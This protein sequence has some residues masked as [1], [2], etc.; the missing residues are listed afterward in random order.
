MQNQ[1]ELFVFAS[2]EIQE[3]LADNQLDLVELLNQEGVEA[4]KGLAMNP[5]AAS[6]NSTQKDPAGVILAS[7]ALVLAITPLITKILTA[8]SHRN[9]VVR[10]LVCVPV[11]NSSGEVVRDQD[12]KPILHWIERSR[13]LTKSEQLQSSTEISLKGPIGLEVSYAD[14]PIHKLSNS[15]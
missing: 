7:A 5:A 9:I 2:S 12:G 8:L 3:L 14:S 15:D 11:E 6:A 1:A 10:E 4:E 13:L